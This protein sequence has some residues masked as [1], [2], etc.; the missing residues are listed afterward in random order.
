VGLGVAE[1]VAPG[2]VGRLIGVRG[3]KG[4]FRFLGARELASGVGILTQRRPA[5]WMWSRVGGDMLDLALLGAALA[6]S[7]SNR[8]RVAV[9]TAAVAGVTA[10]DV[11]SSRQNEEHRGPI[12][13]RE[14]ITVNRSREDCY[15]FWRNFENLPRFMKHLESVRQLDDRR[16]EWVAKAPAGTQVKWTAEITADDEAN[17]ISWKSLPGADVDNEGTVHFQN[18]AGGRGTVIRV[19]IRYSPPAGRVGAMV[20]RLFGEEPEQQIRGDLRRFK[21]MMELGEIVTTKGQPRGV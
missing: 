7:R 11:L 10:L 18:G 12:D 1:L 9:A 20:A 5:E 14:S 17:R 19:S 3:H 13:F 21:Q 4:L 8:T 2:S 6:S 15:Q 16:S